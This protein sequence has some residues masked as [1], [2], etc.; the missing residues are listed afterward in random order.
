MAK[1]SQN[2]A[3]FTH[4]SLVKRAR[5]V[6]V[7]CHRKNEWT[8]IEYEIHGLFTYPLEITPRNRFFLISNGLSSVLLKVD[9]RIKGLL[10]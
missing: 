9:L 5:S 1:K 6:V 3:I 10:W 2:Y 8:L 4:M 7:K